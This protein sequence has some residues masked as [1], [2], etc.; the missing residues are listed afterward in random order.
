MSPDELDVMGRAAEL[1]DVG[2]MAVPDQILDKPGPLDPIETEM[3]RQHTLV[4]ERMLAAS[5]ALLPA[6]GI[7]RATHENWDGSGYPDGLVAG[8]I[9]LAAR[10]IAVC[11]AYHAMISERPYQARV[12]HDEALAELRRCAG[13]KYDPNVVSA[14]CAEFGDAATAEAAAADDIE[15]LPTAL[16][17]PAAIRSPAG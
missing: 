12:A 17:D 9:P 15:P 4:G 1:H 6:S 11:D 5:P 13:S 10:V 14:F 16:R 8:M 7:V 3:V 2:K